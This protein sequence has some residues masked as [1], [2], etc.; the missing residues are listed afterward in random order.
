MEST[1]LVL[2]IK[3]KNGELRTKITLLDVGVMGWPSKSAKR[4]AEGIK[5]VFPSDS[6]VTCPHQ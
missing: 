5:V 3:S 2:D 6:G 4:V 1:R